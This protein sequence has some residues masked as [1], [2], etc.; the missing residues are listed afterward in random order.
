MVLAQKQIGRPVE[1][2]RGPGYEST[3]LC[4]PYFLQWCQKHIYGENI[5]SFNKFC[6]EK[7]FSTCR[8]LKL[9]T[10][11]SLPVSIQSELISDMKSLG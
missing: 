6:W 1:Q 5:D 4:P 8:K 11:L 7:W 3:Q 10:C 9:D 2:N